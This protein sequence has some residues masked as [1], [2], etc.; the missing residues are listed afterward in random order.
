MLITLG[1]LR[2]TLDGGLHGVTTFE[3]VKFALC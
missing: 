3:P 1:T 2:V